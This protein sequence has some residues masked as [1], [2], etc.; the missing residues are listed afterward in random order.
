VR[1]R[2]IRSFFEILGGM[3]LLSLAASAQDAK[4]GKLK[5]SVHPKEAY[6]FIDGKAIGP[7]KRTIKLDVGTHHLVVA[8]YGFKFVERDISIDSHQILPL[9]IQL[10]PVAGDV[11]G[12]RGRIQLEVGMRRAGDAAVLM[13]G[14]KP[15]YFV[16][17]VDEFN[18]DIIK[19]QELI[20]PPGIHELIVTRYG[21]EL[22]S[23]TVTVG[24]NQRVIVNISNGKQVTKDWPRG[25]NELGA[26]VKRFTA[27]T[28]SATIAVA[29]VSGT[30]SANPPNINCSQN[31]QLAWTSSETVEADMSGLS[32]VPTSGERTVSPRQT[33][34]YELTAKGPGG[35]T[36]PS[37]KI[38]V[39][40]TVQ[41]SISASPTEVRYRRIGDKV[42]EQGN[43]T[44]NWS[45][46]NSD[47]S[48]LDPIGSV[49]TTG[50]K[51]VT[52][53]PTQTGDGPVDEER[54]YTL[55]AT[56][57]CGGSDAKTV[58][59]RLKGS[60]E[61]IP[62]VL[63]NS[64]FFPTDYPTKENPELG[65]LRSQ[66]E[67]LKTLASKFKQYLEYDPEAKL[68]LGAFADERGADK[69][70]Q[71]LSGLRAERVKDFLVSE[72]ISADKIDTSSYGKDKPLDK[73]T[74]VDLQARNP[75]QT[76]EERAR[77]FR[78]TWL[79]YNRRVDIV[80]L[81]TNAESTRFYPQQAADSQ[82][83]W[84]R[85]KPARS[86]VTENN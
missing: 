55:T 47:A 64:V 25:S 42:I 14:D 34:V 21:K 77:N 44:L 13:N 27:G 8:N 78:A 79:A 84:Q 62:T 2:V 4:P 9:D 16:G 63:L 83:L 12:P 74:V 20:V 67:V 30:V 6:T 57:V 22:W 58:A 5:I 56:N 71:G 38:E 51:S 66:Q 26:G 59:V 49:D 24:A 86:V 68:A 32:P 81:P 53:T 29:P 31:T 41:S 36:K 37:T 50:S 39:N 43:T 72:G 80:L 75:D 48:S 3:V 65:L 54:K 82:I 28:A 61:P 76:P 52:L 10:E 45:S 60:I 40:T 70:N 35:V 33:T 69:Y 11:P 46:T 18:N 73:A 19:H 23:G 7:G 15:Q 85:P 17:H 1:H